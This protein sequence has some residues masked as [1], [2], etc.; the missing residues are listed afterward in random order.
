MP[1]TAAGGPYDGW[2]PPRPSFLLANYLWMIEQSSDQPRDPKPPSPLPRPKPPS[3]LPRPKP[4]PPRPRGAPRLDMMMRD[5]SENRLGVC[6]PLKIQ[7][8]KKLEII[9]RFRV[10]SL[11]PTAAK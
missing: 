1:R 6:V 3:P 11:A 7:S 4:P 2:N 5:E 9:S 10:Q 8:S